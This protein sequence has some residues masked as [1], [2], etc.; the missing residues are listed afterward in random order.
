M[1]SWYQENAGLNGVES[2]VVLVG[3]EV[4]REAVP[5][6]VQS[7]VGTLWIWNSYRTGVRGHRAVTRSPAPHKLH[8]TA[9]ASCTLPEIDR[10]HFH[11]THY[12]QNHDSSQFRFES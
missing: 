6:F 9:F 7:R 1:E 12:L 4:K 11:L 3:G 8:S 10:K 5:G 2:A